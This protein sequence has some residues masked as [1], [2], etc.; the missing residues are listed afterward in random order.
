MKTHEQIGQIDLGTRRAKLYFD[1][2]IGLSLLD[3]LLF[4]LIYVM[5][6]Q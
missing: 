6:I 3:M 2:D 1:F 5:T 4:R